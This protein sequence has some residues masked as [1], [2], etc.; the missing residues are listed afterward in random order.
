ML[1]NTC[2]IF[3]EWFSWLVCFT[4]S[5]DMGIDCLCHRITLMLLV[6]CNIP[7]FSSYRH[8]QCT[9]YLIGIMS[10]VLVTPW[11]SLLLVCTD[12]RFYGCL[13]VVNSISV[14]DS[15]YFGKLK[16]LTLEG[17]LHLTV[18][19]PPFTTPPP[20]EASYHLTDRWRH[21]HVT[22][23]TTHYLWAEEE[24]VSSLSQ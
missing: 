5:V 11:R 10:Q 20:S 1:T 16:S 19:F 14:I 21:G 22:P 2:V 13:S 7:I 17:S 18:T 15:V 12:S 9:V 3:V 23:T 8:A 24:D 4:K 6:I